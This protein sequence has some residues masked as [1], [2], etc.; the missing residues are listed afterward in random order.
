[1]TVR[2]VC[3]VVLAVALVAAA[4]PAVEDAGAENARSAARTDAEQVVDGVAALTA[5]ND[6]AVGAGAR[7][8]VTVAFD[9]AALPPDIAY[10][11]VGGVPGRHVPGDDAHSDVVAYR[12]EGQS[13]HTLRTNVD[14]H[15][16][17][18]DDGPLVLRGETTLVARF[19]RDASRPTVAVRRARTDREF[20]AGNGTSGQHA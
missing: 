7:R 2:A 1:M 9:D 14:L 20:M 11:A 16:G 13:P 18:G 19:V 3:C 17:E 6:P 15:A 4:A 10:V 8:T 5:T 12:V